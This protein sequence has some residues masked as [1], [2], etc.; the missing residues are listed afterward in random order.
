M[1][2]FYKFNLLISTR[3]SLSLHLYPRTDYQL[4]V[5][6]S[7][8][9]RN[10]KGRMGHPNAQA[11]LASPS[12]VA[13]SAVQGII[14]GPDSLSSLRL[15]HKDLDLEPKYHI[16][17]SPSLKSTTSST[18]AESTTTNSTSIEIMPPFPTQ[19]NG[20]ILFLPADNVSTD[21]IY[22]GEHAE[23]F[24]LLCRLA[25]SS[26]RCCLCF[27]LAKNYCDSSD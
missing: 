11:Y 8:T 25:C 19:I 12:V 22:P 18:L 16:V 6:I 21:A 1:C 14:C 15:E 26:L 23:N 24:P 27:S 13:A 3:S 9:N 17:E 7:A 10:Y 5:G 2:K 4:A 20:P